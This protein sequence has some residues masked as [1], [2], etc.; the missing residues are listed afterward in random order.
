M[1]SLRLDDRKNLMRFVLS[2]L[3]VSIFATEKPAAD[4][5]TAGLPRD[6]ILGLVAQIQKADYEGDRAALKRL[7]GDLAPVPQDNK[8]LASRVLY[9][10]G[11][12]LWRRAFNGFNESTP[13]K[14][15]EE[16]LNNAIVDFKDRK[17][18]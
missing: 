15:L 17:S 4:Q 18:V 11:F 3:A 14:E 6:S 8:K 5:T 2:L 9:W 12:A 1:S 16:D 7:Y 10:R 13:P